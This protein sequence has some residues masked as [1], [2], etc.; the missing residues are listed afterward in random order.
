MEV[1]S[2]SGFKSVIYCFLIPQLSDQSDHIVHS[3]P[4]RILAHGEAPPNRD[5][6][7][8][9]PCRDEQEREI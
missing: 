5:L 1:R 4:I 6:M 7:S 9:S 8:L 2:C 3:L